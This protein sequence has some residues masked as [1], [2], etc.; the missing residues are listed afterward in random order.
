MSI[1]PLPPGDRHVAS[2]SFG[3]ACI[4]YCHIPASGADLT[5]EADSGYNPM[6]LAV[7]LGHKEGKYMNYE[8]NSI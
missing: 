2:S 5:F 3:S 7:A 4:Y 6:D 1:P 8:L